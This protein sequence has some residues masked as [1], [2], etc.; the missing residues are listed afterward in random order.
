MTTEEAIQWIR[1]SKSTGK[2][3]GSKGLVDACDMAIAALQAKQERDNPK[4]LTLEEL[5]QMD[6]EPVWLVDGS[7]NEM[8]GL[9]DAGDDHPD[10]IDS[11]C[12]LW[13]GEFYNMSGD[14][15][16]GLH[17]IGWLAYRRKPKEVKTKC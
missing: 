4:P 15:K 2:I 14:G 12:G 17:L 1:E 9:V 13:R 5:R 10:V 8:W 11:Q 7:G 16:N 6:G 3:V